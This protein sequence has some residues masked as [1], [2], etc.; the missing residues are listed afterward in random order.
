MLGHPYPRR[1][2]LLCTAARRSPR[3][4][5]QHACGAYS[6]KT[7]PVAQELAPDAKRELARSLAHS[8]RISLTDKVPGVYMA[9]LSL[10]RAVTNPGVVAPRECASLVADLA[11]LLIDKVRLVWL[12]LA[13]YALGICAML[14]FQMMRIG[15]YRSCRADPQL[16]TCQKNHIDDLEEAG[17]ADRLVWKFSVSCCG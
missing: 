10:L 2:T 12:A 5:T 15:L 16:F 17:R 3:V 6:N 13:V 14:T 8:L 11:P 1:C 7:F 4:T 9:G